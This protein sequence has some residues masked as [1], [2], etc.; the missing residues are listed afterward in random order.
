ME[1]DSAT[2]AVLA[3]KLIPAIKKAGLATKIWV[4]ETHELNPTGDYDSY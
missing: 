4:S 1:M 2:Q 3:N